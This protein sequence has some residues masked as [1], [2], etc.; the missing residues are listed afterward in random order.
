VEQR[1]EDWLNARAGHV[2]A[3][4][5]KNVRAKIKSGEA[6]G[7]KNYRMK[8]VMERIAQAPINEGYTS[9]EMQ[10]GIDLEPI[11]R[12]HYEAFRGVLVTEVGFVLHP[13]IKGFG[14][15]PDGLVG[16]DGLVEIKC[17]NISTHI[18]YWMQDEP[19]SEYIDQMLAQLA[20]TGRKWCDFVSYDD[21]VAEDLRLVVIRFEPKKEEIEQLEKEVIEFLLEVEAEVEKINQ[22]RSRK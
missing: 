14:A 8:L 6:A 4:G 17:P 11:A 2:T 12:A 21:R 13:T 18:G 1:T 20:C 16:E 22:R 19:P 15:S 3:S 10:R 7:R 9:A 5:V